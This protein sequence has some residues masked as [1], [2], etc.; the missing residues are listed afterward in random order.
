MTKKKKRN[1]LIILT[2]IYTIAILFLAIHSINEDKEIN[3]NINNI[4]VKCMNGDYPLSSGKTCKDILEN[5]HEI[6]FYEIFEK[7]FYH[8][9]AVIFIYN[10]IFVNL[11]SL[12]WICKIL[13]NKMVSHYYLRTNK[14]ELIKKI[15]KESYCY[16]LP[17]LISFIFLI[18]FL[19]L[20]TKVVVSNRIDWMTTTMKYPSLFILFI[21]V[22]LIL[23]T[24]SFI[25][26]GLIIARKVQ[27]YIL[28]IMIAIL[29]L[30]AYE[31]ILT[32]L[33]GE[34]FNIYAYPYS[35]INYLVIHD[36]RGLFISLLFPLLLFIISFIIVII[37]F[38]NKEK[39]YLSCERKN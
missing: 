17:I 8:P 26:I 12:I 34:I 1:I 28:T 22:N 33:I 15:F 9:V 25:N 16:I 39:L 14:K 18:I 32:R 13:K 19:L 3:N 29:F 31:V 11:F 10:F 4:Y 20:N 24:A 21:F 35:L 37:V 30:F 7:M 5:V 27:N 36:E 2:L 23:F 6:N 38:G